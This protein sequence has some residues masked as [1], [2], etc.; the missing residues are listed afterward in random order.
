MMRM[1][2]INLKIDQPVQKGQPEESDNDEPQG[3]QGK[4]I[5]I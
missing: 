3:Q 1:M 4:K 2:K 5:V